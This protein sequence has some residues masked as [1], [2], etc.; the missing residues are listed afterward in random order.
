[1]KDIVKNFLAKYLDTKLKKAVAA[2]VFAA[3]FALSQAYCPPC[4]VV[5]SGIEL[6]S[7]E[8]PAE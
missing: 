6:P 5:L 2:A 1:M 3:L 8:Q 7:A 4:A